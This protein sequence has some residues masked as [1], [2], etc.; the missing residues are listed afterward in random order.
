MDPYNNRKALVHFISILSDPA[1]VDCLDVHGY[2]LTL[3]VI[4][5]K[6]CD[7]LGRTSNDPS[8][9]SYFAIPFNLLYYILILF[10][11]KNN[12]YNLD[13]LKSKLKLVQDI[14]FDNPFIKWIYDTFRDTEVGFDSSYQE[15]LQYFIS[16]LLEN[17]V[18]NI[19]TK[20]LNDHSPW[21]I[22]HKLPQVLFLLYSCSEKNLTSSYAI[23]D[24]MSTFI[25]I[26][27]YSS[28]VIFTSLAKT[29]MAIDTELIQTV[30]SNFNT[31]NNNNSNNN[32]GNNNSNETGGGMSELEMP[33]T[34]FNSKSRDS[35]F[36]LNHHI[37]ETLNLILYP[38]LF[39]CIF[40][41]PSDSNQHQS[42]LFKNQQQQQQMGTDIIM[43]L[44]RCPNTITM[45]R[46][47][48]QSILQPCS[49][50]NNNAPPPIK[51]TDI[52][53]DLLRVFIERTDVHHFVDAL[54]TVVLSSIVNTVD[55]SENKFESITSSFLHLNDTVKTIELGGYI[56]G[57]IVG[58]ESISILF[59]SI[60]P[61]NSKTLLTSSLKGQLISY[62]CFNTLI[63][64][65]A[66]FYISQNDRYI[67]SV[68]AKF[69]NVIN[70]CAKK[71]VVCEEKSL[72]SYITSL[73]SLFIHLNKS[74][75][76]NLISSSGGN[77]LYQQTTTTTTKT[78]KKQLN[79]NK[80]N[81]NH[82]S[83]FSI[84][85][86]NQFDELL[87]SINSISNYF[88]AGSIYT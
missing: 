35:S 68:L 20:I 65:N 25:R 26:V 28:I 32:N 37:P 10:N 63:N 11:F 30:L 42:C 31:N 46:L 85:P 57:T 51:L 86:S 14:S 78:S 73:L 33:I 22:V 49:D 58:I 67:T 88:L 40:T 52:P 24:M 7:S 12:Q 64:A 84:I 36:Q 54:A 76:Y 56:L 27:P 74:L 34:L 66:S 53:T 8:I 4:L 39:K 80:N 71:L 70:S 83:I 16:S 87:I 77:Q 48:F 72:Q 6:Q 3:L 82:D 75:K 59:N 5:I 18:D 41:N 69:F 44:F 23:S 60:I 29:P 19:Q 50:P 47:L 13:L 1:V 15:S 21:Q 17:N 81:K 79:Y 55:I 9:H 43:Q 61:I 45:L 2:I 62:F 38:V